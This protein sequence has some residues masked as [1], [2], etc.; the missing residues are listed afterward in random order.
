MVWKGP[1]IAA[2]PQGTLS[3]KAAGRVAGLHWRT[4]LRWADRGILNPECCYGTR[5]EHGSGLAWRLH[6][7]VAARTIAELRKAGL[8]AQQVRIAGAVVAASGGNF[9][10]V[11]L[12]SDGRD[13]FRVLSGNRLLSVLNKPGQHHL[14]TLDQWAA[15]VRKA[16]EAELEHRRRERAA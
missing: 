9:S 14:F 12:W 16:F 8:S 10:S 5:G 2:L 1:Q 11:K 3:T 6:D 4:L 13:A 7:L 15:P